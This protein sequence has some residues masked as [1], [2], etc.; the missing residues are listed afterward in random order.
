[1]YSF[2]WLIDILVSA[3][4]SE[5]YKILVGCMT[6]TSPH[7]QSASI[8]VLTRVL[9]AYKTDSETQSSLVNI[10]HVIYELMKQKNREVIK[11][12]LGFVKTAVKILPD[13]ILMSE[14]KNICEALLLWSKDP[15][16]RFRMKVWIIDMK[17]WNRFVSLW[18]IWWN[19]SV[20]MS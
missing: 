3:S 14:L 15:K 16:N 6:S 18:R 4:L 17:T 20:E 5:Y 13:E 10:M 12:C 1:M 19:E 9:Y 8:Q 7:L 2:H 11:S